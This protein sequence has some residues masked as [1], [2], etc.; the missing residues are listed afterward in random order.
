VALGPISALVCGSPSRSMITVGI[1]GTNGKTTTAQLAAG[2]LRHHGWQ[3]SV[4]GTLQGPRTTPEAPE[5]QTTLASFLADGADATVMEV[6]SHALALHRVDGTV[7]DV[8]AFT[9]LGRDHLDLHGSVEQYFRAKARLFDPRF[10]PVAVINV[11]D[12]HGSVLADSLKG[13]DGLRVV[14]MSC[15]E[16][17]D[18]RVTATSHS[19]D[20]RGLRVQVPLGGHFNVA[21]SLCALTVAIELGLP[22][23]E[24]IAG[25][26]Q[27]E[28][29]P[30]R[31][32]PIT[33]AADF[34]FEVIVDYAHTAEGLEEV[35]SSVRTMAASSA[36]V[37]VVF[38]AGGERDHDKRPVMGAAA[39]RLSDV[40]VVTSDNPR[41]EDA[42]SIIDDIVAGMKG[43]DAHARVETEL[44]RRDAIARAL[45]IAQPGDVVVIAGKGHETTQDLGDV[46]VEFDDRA[47]AR[48]LLEARR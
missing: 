42:R 13:V 24:A 40:A 5:L 18:V 36:A 9:N 38:G 10:A 8:V 34:G 37:I 6:S 27:A 23:S 44:D 11:D 1:T 35:L 14:P 31:F 46:V 30:G 16:L 3:T 43:V 4:I 2:I 7:F 20:W 41:H 15:S 26:A 17:A 45:D 48:Q 33:E 22:A 12:P 47:T 28:A 25:L 19:Y 39:A 21:N 32:E 29:V